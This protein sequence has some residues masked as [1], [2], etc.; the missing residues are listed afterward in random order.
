MDALTRQLAVELAPHGITV[1]AIAPGFIEVE[2][3]MAS[4]EDYSREEVARN[5]PVGRVGFPNDIGSLLCYLASEQASFITGA[6]IN[7]DGGSMAKLSF[8][9]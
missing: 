3:T 4:F 2:R 9:P 1:N 6:V 8:Q 5:I 7:C